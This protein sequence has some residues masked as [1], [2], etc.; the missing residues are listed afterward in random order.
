MPVKPTAVDRLIGWFDPVA[1]ARRLKARTVTAL[2]GS[3]TGASRGRRTLAGWQTPLGSA[4][5]N[6]L[7]DLPAL[8]E[9]SRDLIRNYPVATGALQTNVTRVVGTG[10]SLQ[11]RVRRELLGWTEDQ[12]SSWQR[13]TE[14]EFALW[15]ESESCDCARTLNFYGLQALAFR[16]TLESG[17]C[18]ALLPS[19]ERAGHPYRLAVQLIEA[20]RVSNPQGRSDLPELTAGIERDPQGAPV[21]YHVAKYHPGDFTGRRNEWT[22]VAAFGPRTGRR[23]CLHLYEQL[24]PGQS[25]GVPYLAP[26]IEPLRQLGQY[27]EAELTAAIVAGF[28]AVFVKSEADDGLAPAESATTGNVPSGAENTSAA[29]DGTLSP[30]LV[31][32]LG[33]G[34]SIETA[35][36]MRPNSQFDPFCLAVLRQVGVALGLPFEVLIKHFTASYSA[37]RAALLEAWAFFKCRRVWLAGRFCQPIYASWMEEAVSLGRIAAPGCFDDPLKRWAY[38]ASQWVGDEPGSIDPLKE[39]QAA[40]KRLEIGITTL[41]E[42][43]LAYDGGDWETKHPQ[44]AHERRVRVADGLVPFDAA[45]DREPPLEPDFD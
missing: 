3:Y 41:S 23:V 29:W 9:R 33:R 37:A 20:D 34:E 32:D 36:P 27:T 26:V 31:A 21:A 19:I 45:Q 4:D 39:V 2:L 13:R 30:G 6:T 24:R 18:L 17:D 42:E 43:T 11:S 15:A 38:L 25:R 40:E 44:Q 7:Y 14:Q 8:R 16:S 28:F 12:A 35:N 1:G 10:L 5:A 22:R